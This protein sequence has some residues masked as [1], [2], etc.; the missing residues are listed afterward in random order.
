VA[1]GA[2]RPFVWRRLRVRHLDGW[3]ELTADEHWRRLARASL[4]Q[5]WRRWTRHR[6]DCRAGPCDK[7][8]DQPIQGNTWDQCPD[9]ALRS[10]YWQAI[11]HVSAA[12]DLGA[13]AGWPDAYSGGIV[14]GVR[15]LRIERSRYEAA[16][17]ER[18]SKGK[19]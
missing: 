8:P 16:Q 4:D 3:R 5:S 2:D 7:A 12:L 15:A 13:V 14:D 17:M 11:C 18:A 6:C 19:A 1:G 10:P 9:G